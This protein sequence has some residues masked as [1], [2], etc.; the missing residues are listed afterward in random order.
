MSGAHRDAALQDGLYSQGIVITASEIPKLYTPGNFS[1]SSALALQEGTAAATLSLR[2]AWN[3]RR[4]YDVLRNW[5]E[6]SLPARESTQHL[7]YTTD[8]Y[9]VEVREFALCLKDEQAGCIDRHTVR[10]L[11]APSVRF[12]ASSPRQD[13]QCCGSWPWRIVLAHTRRWS[14]R[15]RVGISFITAYR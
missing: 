3:T 9:K 2:G 1:K 12:R 5:H 15:A 10:M 4:L 14:A 7:P 6:R 11:T 8:T 13:M